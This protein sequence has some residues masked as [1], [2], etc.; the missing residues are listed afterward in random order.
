[1][2]RLRLIQIVII[3]L[4]LSHF[5]FATEFSCNSKNVLANFDN[6]LKIVQKKEDMHPDFHILFPFKSKVRDASYRT[7]GLFLEEYVETD[8]KNKEKLLI[9]VNCIKYYYRDTEP[10][11]VTKLLKC[12]K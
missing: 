6:H 12:F 9:W 8:K 5:A 1:M 3:N 7:C 11:T 4:L 10:D 2:C